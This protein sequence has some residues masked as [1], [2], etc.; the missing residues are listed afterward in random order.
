MM[1]RRTTADERARYAFVHEIGISAA[2]G[3]SGT[4]HC[5]HLR[6]G[7]PVFGKH[8]PGARKPHYVWT[9]PLLFEEHMIEQH[10][11]N[12]QEFWAGYGFDWLD[13]IRSPL[14]V[15]L[16]LEGFRALGDADAARGWLR[17]GR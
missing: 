3:R 6:S 8:N 1:T 2:S 17:G 12:E 15:A 11:M 10:G 7:A 13:P 9:L 5:A 16:A 4:I 14:A